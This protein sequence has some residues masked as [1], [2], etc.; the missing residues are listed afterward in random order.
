M[1]ELGLP[2]HAEPC[3]TRG[4]VNDIPSVVAVQVSS[5]LYGRSEGLKIKKKQCYS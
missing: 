5:Q 1:S 4:R 3:R 2:S